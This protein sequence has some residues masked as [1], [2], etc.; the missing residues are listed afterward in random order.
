[1]PIRN[2][3]F[4]TGNR[5]YRTAADRKAIARGST[6]LIKDIGEDLAGPSIYHVDFTMEEVATIALSFAI[7]E[8]DDISETYKSIARLCRKHDVPMIMAMSNKLEGRSQQD[9]DNF[10]QDL[11]TGQ[12]TPPSEAH[13]WSLGR[14]KDGQQKKALQSSRISSLLLARELEGNQGF[15]RTRQYVNFQNEFKTLREDDLQVVAEFTNCAG[16]ITT[17]SW[18]SGESFLC[19]TT[20]H[21]DTHNQQYNK[22]GNLLLCSTLKNTLRAFADH[23]IP[24][25]KVEKGE[26]SIEAMRRSQDPWLYSSVVSS[27]YDKANDLAYT[28]GFDKT[29]KVWKV[30]PAGDFMDVIA[31]WHH[32]GNVNFVAAAR[33]GSGRVATAADSPTEA[34]RVYTFNK[35]DIDESPYQSFSCSRNDAD[36]SDKWAYYPATMQWGRAPGTQ[37]LLLVGYS[38]RSFSGDDQDIPE[39]KRSSGEITLW[40]AIEGRRVPV[41]TLSTANVFEAAWH[42]DLQCFITATTPCGPNVGHDVRT[43]VHIFQH[44]SKQPSVCYSQFQ[45]LDCFAS[46]INELTIMPNSKVHAYITAACT[47]GKTY[48]WD[49]AQGDKPVHILKHGKPLDEYHGDREREDTGVKFTAWGSSPD[50]FYT[51]SSDGAVKVWNVRKRRKPFIR[52]LLEAPGPISF[53]GFSPNKSKLAIGDATGRVFLL[54]LDERDVPEASYITLPGTTKRIRRSKPFIPHPE[55]LPPYAGTNADEHDIDNETSDSEIGTYTRRT[56]LDTQQLTLTDNPVIGAVQGPQYQATGL[57]RHDAHLQED[58]TLPLLANFECRQ[59]NSEAASRG[60]RRRS[61][62]R[63]KNPG[64][65]DKRLQGVHADNQ[66]RDLSVDNIQDKETQELV[67]EAALLAVDEDWGLEFE[68]LPGPDGFLGDDITLDGATFI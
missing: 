43:Q 1:M 24:R 32:A 52:N 62:R 15:H 48:V 5:P 39:D 53:G 58:P 47:D 40:D 20:T 50:R 59:L 33:D 21:S 49:T 7:L 19:G 55:P 51:G 65:P 63:V 3:F 56:Y 14:E 25:P 44:D 12:A 8:W 10:C 45:S 11:V 6:H 61:M 34:V 13:V 57:F 46:D 54:S 66:R 60:R 41:L 2:N 16:D 38:P 18:V 23:R 68:E 30:D 67:R 9:V 64:L 29:V 42:P 26:N 4:A 17:G 22:P 31:T 36:G 27:D 28:S 37:H 35:D